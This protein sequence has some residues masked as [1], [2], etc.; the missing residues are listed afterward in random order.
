MSL[1]NSKIKILAI[2]GPTATGKSDLAVLLAKKFGGEVVSA[3]SRQVYTGLDIGSGK[4]T[5]KETG[6]IPHHMLDIA[7]P[8]HTYTVS[9]YQ[10]RAQKEIFAIAKRKKLPIVCGGSGFYIQAAIDNISF[11]DVPPNTKLRKQLAVQSPE[12]LYNMLSALDLERADTIDRHN[13]RRLIRALE[14]VSAQGRVP[15]QIQQSY[16]EPLIIGIALPKNVLN[17]RIHIRLQKRFKKGMIREVQ[18]L[19]EQGVSWKKL[20]SFGLEYRFVATYLQKK[21]TRP[22]MQEK[23]EIAIRQF[24]KR[25]MTWFKRD[26]RIHWFE[27]E[28]QQEINTAVEKFLRP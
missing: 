15:K 24:A 4:V 17:E 13:P 16:F 28:R 22:E 27:P 26:K 10:K 3:D 11:P 21:L 1:Q 19:H 2:V 20:A 8:K 7:N 18:K 6:G 5:K 9:Q 12:K 14:I 25:Q 23:L